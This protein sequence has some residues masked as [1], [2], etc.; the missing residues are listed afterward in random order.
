MRSVGSIPMH[1]RHPIVWRVFSFSRQVEAE[2][3]CCFSVGV[4][5]T[6]NLEKLLA[7]FQPP[8]VSLMQR[9]RYWVE[10]QPAELAYCFLEDG[11]HEEARLTYE[12][13]DRKARAVASRLQQLRMAGQRLAALSAGNRFPRRLVR[14][15]L[16]RRGGRARL[17]AAA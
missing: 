5:A 10:H 1:F 15:L 3:I 4:C 14:L 12:Q 2:I 6:V 16:R 7:P 17:S 9:L 13:L 11:D 8:S